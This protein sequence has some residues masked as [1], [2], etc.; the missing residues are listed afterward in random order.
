MSQERLGDGTVTLSGD[1]VHALS[2]HLGIILGFV[3]LMLAEAA[4]DDP[5]RQDL[6]E[7]RR[8]ARAAA[9]LMKPHLTT[10][11]P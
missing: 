8:A 4:D 10:E 11:E 7:I 3:E 2:N 5:R 9:G 6:L 1:A